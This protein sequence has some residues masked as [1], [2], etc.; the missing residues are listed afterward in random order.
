VQ[1]AGRTDRAVACVRRTL[2]RLNLSDNTFGL[3]GATALAASVAKMP[4][5]RWLILRDTG[6]TED[7]AILVCGATSG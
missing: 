3:G 6:L 7:G 2:Q 4:A 1:I 5:M